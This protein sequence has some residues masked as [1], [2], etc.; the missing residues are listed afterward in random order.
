M[1]DYILAK[2]QLNYSVIFILPD[3]V[4]VSFNCV[5]IGNVISRPMTRLKT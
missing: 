4:T 5:D 3:S 2:F 1:E